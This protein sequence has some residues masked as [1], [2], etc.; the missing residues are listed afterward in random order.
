MAVFANTTVTAAVVL[1]VV[2]LGGCDDEPS[3]NVDAGMNDAGAELGAPDSRWSV[4]AAIDSAPTVD[5]ASIPDRLPDPDRAP[6]PDRQRAPDRS[7]GVDRG[8]PDATTPSCA[9]AKQAVLS[10][11]ARLNRCTNTGDCAYIWG[12]CPFGCHI[13]H[14]KADSTTRLKTL[15]T[16]YTSMK[17][18]P[19]C[20][21]RCAP[22]G[23]LSCTAGVCT[24]AYP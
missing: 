19:Q 18:C 2:T 14:N 9:A 23:T 15:M 16:A 22:P 20:T 24:M 4:D 3:G 12:V 8:A 13:P 7:P 17:Q 6:A 11:I 21:Y 5:R 1:A 10:E